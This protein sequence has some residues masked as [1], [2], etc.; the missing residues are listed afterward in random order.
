[1]D[2]KKRVHDF[3][4]EASCGESLYFQGSDQRAYEAQAQTRYELEPYIPEFCGF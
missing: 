3:W 4:N 1:M 2:S